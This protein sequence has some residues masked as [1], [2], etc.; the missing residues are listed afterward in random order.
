MKTLIDE[1]TEI[2][3]LVVD[4]KTYKSDADNGHSNPEW[5]E[6]DRLTALLDAPNFEDATLF[7][8]QYL[9][10]C[11]SF[12]LPSLAVCGPKRLCIHVH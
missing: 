10:F 11:L 5:N 6:H 8:H 1:R 2:P 4:I 3:P 7:C 12:S 9:T